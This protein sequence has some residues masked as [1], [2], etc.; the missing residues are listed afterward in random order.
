MVPFLP[1]DAVSQTA[2]VKGVMH[3]ADTDALPADAGFAS[4]LS[5][6]ADLTE[7]PP[8]P[9][10][11]TEDG[12][13]S[14]EEEL[15]LLAKNRLPD[16]ADGD[17]SQ[18]FPA[19]PQ[20]VVQNGRAVAA[21]DA[22]DGRPA[23]LKRQVVQA[24]IAPGLSGMMTS[25]DSGPQTAAVSG[26][27]VAVP[28]VDADGN[29]AAFRN[30]LSPDRGQQLTGQSGATPAGG[31]DQPVNGDTPKRAAGG[32]NGLP[33]DA[34]GTVM[35][36]VASASGVALHGGAPKAGL[37]PH[38][39]QQT[40]PLR[41]LPMADRQGAE[42][43]KSMLVQ[44]AAG[45]KAAGSMLLQTPKGLLHPGDIGEGPTKLSDPIH[46]PGGATPERLSSQP[47]SVTAS[48]PQGNA[49]DAARHA[50]SQMA[51]AIAQKAGQPTDIAL[52]PEELGRVRMSLSAAENSV[53][54]TVLADRPETAD[55]MRRHIDILAQEFRMLGYDDIT[56]AFEGQSD[57]GAPGAGVD[58]R[59]EA[60]TTDQHEETEQDTV[61]PMM[62][63]GALDLRI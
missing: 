25:G 60:P 15:D 53:T 52:Q 56:F 32:T 48:M 16:T 12:Q 46:G 24:G 28:S 40:D 6:D 59:A 20:D 26:Q 11:L 36:G 7:S 61:I 38:A 47:S 37:F 22:L 44:A 45:P 63:E 34:T 57:S 50:A 14:G 2:P 58:E 33:S 5:D 10:A 1:V 9:S 42:S 21:S 41:R 54:L 29:S 62:P 19:T 35:K 3:R 17:P 39:E 49:P 27:L 55:L 4:F 23:P 31:P 13:P 30:G 51:V 43:G 8:T 18:P